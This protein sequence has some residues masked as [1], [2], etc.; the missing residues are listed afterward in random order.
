MSEGFQERLKEQPAKGPSQG[1][2]RQDSGAAQAP[3]HQDKSKAVGFNLFLQVSAHGYQQNTAT[4]CEE[5]QVHPQTT[6]AGQRALSLSLPPSH[7]FL[8]REDKGC[9]GE[10][11]LF[12]LPQPSDTARK[13]WNHQRGT[14]S[15]AQKHTTQ[16]ESSRWLSTG[17]P[18]WLCCPSKPP[19]VPHTLS[20]GCP[21]PS[22]AAAF[23]WTGGSGDSAI[24]ASTPCQVC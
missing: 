2:S 23:S 13:G 11:V 15:L 19:Q 14:G 1:L 9:P 16:A 22:R 12:S 5:G 24:R 7:T 20:P 21:F 6:A 8:S 17:S 4:S 10:P 3:S 18:A